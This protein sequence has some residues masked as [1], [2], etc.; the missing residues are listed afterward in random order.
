MWCLSFAIIS[1][2]CFVVD[3]V[4]LRR[5]GI[6]DTSRSII[7]SRVHGIRILE[8]VLGDTQTLQVS[9]PG[10]SM[11]RRGRRWCSTILGK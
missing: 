9:I 4:L 11:S 8:H 3:I 1:L 10:L 2:Q 5:G 6:S 7:A